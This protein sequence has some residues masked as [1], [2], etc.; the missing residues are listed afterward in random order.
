MLIDECNVSI[1]IQGTLDL[2]ER[3]FLIPSNT[4][5]EHVFRGKFLDFLINRRVMRQFP[6]VCIIRAAVDDRLVDKQQVF[7]VGIRIIHAV[8][9]AFQCC[10]G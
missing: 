7:E 3:S 10:F 4:S 9:Q 5:E 2:D 8:V 6:N 1:T